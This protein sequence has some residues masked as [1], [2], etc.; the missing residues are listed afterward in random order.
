MQRTVKELRERAKQLGITG[1]WD[2]NKE[3]LGLAIK[4]AESTEAKG[5][6]EEENGS[7]Q[8]EAVLEV[9]EAVPEDDI[10]VVI[11][12]GVKA[13]YVKDAEVGTL[14]AFDDGTGNI[15]SAK[16]VNKST[17]RQML[18]LENRAGIEYIV[19]WTSVIWV[20]SGKRW[21]KGVFKLLTGGMDGGK[22][23]RA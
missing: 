21:P 17:K 10:P 15:R 22:S 14:V 7:C 11:D 19:P 18:K 4:A 6:R 9:V 23:S 1:R 16:I 5:S 12:H 8:A 3:E 20:R 2:M 13:N